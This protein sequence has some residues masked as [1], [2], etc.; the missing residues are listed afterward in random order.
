MYELVGH[1][2]D[3]LIRYPD[4]GKLGDVKSLGRGRP[5]KLDCNISG[6]KVSLARNIEYQNHED[7]LPKQ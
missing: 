4:Y 3:K 2:T 5:E 7:L 1:Q 6:F